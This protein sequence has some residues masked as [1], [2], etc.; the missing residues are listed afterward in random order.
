MNKNNQGSTQLINWINN[1]V[2]PFYYQT[3]ITPKRIYFLYAFLGDGYQIN[4]EEYVENLTKWKK[5]HSQNANNTKDANDHDPI[6]TTTNNT[7]ITTDNTNNKEN[8]SITILRRGY[9]Q[10]DN[11][12]KENFNWFWLPY[13]QYPKNIQRCDIIR[14]MLMYQFG[15]VYSDLDVEPNISIDFLLNK[16]H[17]A[18]VIFGV[19][20]EKPI[21]KC[22]NT[23][24]IE[25]IRKGVME[26]PTRIANYFFISRIPY[27]PIWIDILKLA[28]RRASCTINSQYGI[29][30]TTGP[31]VVTTVLSNNRNKYNDIAII[32]H[33]EFIKM[34]PHSCS[35]F[36]DGSWR[37]ASRLP[38]GENGYNS[39]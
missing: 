9:D 1:K 4:K 20:R 27:H 15:G 6:N 26:I 34:Y 24:R 19:G 21:E 10:L 7:N 5:T 28:K 8:W 2:S 23:T 13:I 31:D 11:F 37:K 33:K 36:S 12:V 29:I 18:N 38:I 22:R 14:Y 39:I 32:P 3:N 25:T 16:Y 17:W 30:Y 35:S